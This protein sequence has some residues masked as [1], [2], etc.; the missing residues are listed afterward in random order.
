MHKRCTD[1]EDGTESQNSADGIALGGFR[2]LRSIEDRPQES[3]VKSTRW[4]SSLAGRV[5]AQEEGQGG[6]ERERGRKKRE[7]QGEKDG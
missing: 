5:Y 1:E 3:S 2:R 6:L 7:K 4:E